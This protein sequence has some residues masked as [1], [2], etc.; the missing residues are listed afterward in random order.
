MVLVSGCCV[1]LAGVSAPLHEGRLRAGWNVEEAPC[2]IIARKTGET[3]ALVRVPAAVG[4]RP[5]A[6]VRV[7][8]ATNEVPVSVVWAD[9][10]EG[11]TALADVTAAP[12]G[13]QLRIYPIPG[14]A[15]AVPALAEARVQDP[16]P[17]WGLARRTA[18][19]DFPRSRDDLRMLETRFD[20]RPGYFAVADFAGLPATS[21][22][23]PE[24]WFQGTWMRM[25]HLVDLQTWLLVPA[26]AEFRFGLVG[27]SPAWLMIDGEEVLAH[28][29]YRPGD[30]WT[31]S[32]DLPLKA[33]LRR[34]QVRTV[35]RAR[36]DTALAWKRAGEEGVAA[37]VVMVT[38]SGLLSGR[39]ERR[40][41]RIHPYALVET[42]RAYR[43]SGTEGAFVPFTCVNDT[44][45]AATGTVALAWHINDAF[46]GSGLTNSLIL[47]TTDL[48]GRLRLNVQDASGATA[49]HTAQLTFDGPI[50]AEHDVTSRMTGVPAVCYSDD[51]VQPIIRIRTTAPDGMAFVL[52]GIISWRAGGATNITSAVTTANGWAQ[53]YLCQFE[54][55]TAETLTW[56][57]R[58]AGAAVS[59][60]KAV[61]A[62]E[63]FSVL[64]DEVSGDCLTS[65]GT[66]VVLVAAHASRGEPVATAGRG[67]AVALLDGFLASG[68]GL[69]E[70]S[71]PADW[72]RM[73][74]RAL[75]RREDAPGMT[76]L[77]PFAEVKNVLPAATIVFAPSLTETS[78]QGG[79]GTFERRVSAMAGLLSGP[80]C[81]SPR[82][83]L[84]V[85]PEFDVLPGCGCVPGD[86]PC[87]HALEAS[88]Y[89]QAIIRVADVYALET[90][91]LFNAFK[92]FRTDAP[93]VRDG[94]L[95]PK[96]ASIAMGLIFKK[97]GI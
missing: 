4:D 86:A 81:G 33:G 6:A 76:W 75:E 22:P 77:L 45:L 68:A 53:F 59:G 42:G 70:A 94:G 32:Q 13:A 15:L 43:F 64:P 31:A 63:P 95:T 60:G 85:P 2:R 48:P 19:M 46:T 62:H 56:E 54:V 28:P 40:E 35:C 50:W 82:V 20:G 65:E 3:F 21:A 93:L 11:V 39:T 23:A 29:P 18:G 72:K 36:I 51:V 91:N 30:A 9:A 10:E 67:G 83:I 90:V 38:G 5:V 71:I 24:G 87:V 47:R 25:S 12:R 84:V 44:T 79:V 52:E 78:L 27:T 92:T 8:Y 7:F 97:I 89:A 37:D 61:F 58:H 41:E 96:G 74:L 17:L 26:D 57:L 69:N 88:A 49:E 73:D 1:S 16:T 14:E 34:V 55:S 66:A 80:A